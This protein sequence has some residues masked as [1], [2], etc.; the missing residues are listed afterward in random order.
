MEQE[1]EH[2]RELGQELVEPLLA[3]RRPTCKSEVLKVL[4]TIFS[5][6]P[7]Y[8]L[9]ASVDIT[10]LT[11]AWFFKLPAYMS[12]R[13]RFS[14]NAMA[15]FTYVNVFATIGIF[16]ASA[17]VVPAVPGEYHGLLTH[18]LPKEPPFTKL[19][20]FL[21]LS[22][23]LTVARAGARKILHRKLL[24]S[25]RSVADMA[26][27]LYECDCV[28][29]NFTML[30]TAIGLLT[31]VH[32]STV[33]VMT[34]HGMTESQAIFVHVATRLFADCWVADIIL[35]TAW[36][37]IAQR[38]ETDFQN[39]QTYRMIAELPSTTSSECPICLSDAAIEYCRLPCGHA[40]HR[41]CLFSWGRHQMTVV[42]CPLCRLSI[43]T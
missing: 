13:A 12:W 1:Q 43:G 25:N 41:E 15:L 18:H 38:I 24:T 8:S 40:F 42:T 14:I 19:A 33:H 27:A 32:G 2:G 3:S 6:V 10:T 7:L 36:R 30:I 39:S 35:R 34:G 26:L 29:W 17:V 22:L 37:W 5:P 20:Y 21:V 11:S 31:S 4:W 9:A 23:A 28:A 16:V